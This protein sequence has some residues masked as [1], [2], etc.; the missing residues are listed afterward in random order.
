[1]VKSCSQVMS[2]YLVKRLP[3]KNL[4][5]SENSFYFY[6]FLQKVIVFTAPQLCVLIVAD[7]GRSRSFLLVWRSPLRRSWWST[8][9]KT[10]AGCTPSAR[11]NT[12][13]HCRMDSQASQVWLLNLTTLKISIAFWVKCYASSPLYMHVNILYLE[14]STS[15]LF[16]TLAYIRLVRDSP[17]MCIQSGSTRRSVNDV[18][19]Q[20]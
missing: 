15:T 17:T 2:F 18:Q 4:L 16:L 19:Y 5:P 3:I 13:T 20:I 1:M 14:Y 12:S 10:E 8:G 7:V 6:M 11:R 9:E